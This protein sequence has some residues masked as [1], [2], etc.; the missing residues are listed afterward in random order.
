[1][2]LSLLFVGAAFGIPIGQ[3]QNPMSFILPYY[4]AKKINWSPPTYNMPN[5]NFNPFDAGSKSFITDTIMP[6]YL[7]NRYDNTAMEAMNWFYYMKK[8]H[9]LDLI[10]IQNL[11]P[12]T[13]LAANRGD[14][15]P[16]KPYVPESVNMIPEGY[17]G[18]SF[19]SFGDWGN[20]ADFFV[21]SNNKFPGQ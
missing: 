1:M 6:A 21:G 10:G 20:S 13:L 18:Q 11:I 7:T 12:A 2:K 8:N 4:M 3:G 5:I 15:G 14:T 16:V 17:E 19:G 9:P